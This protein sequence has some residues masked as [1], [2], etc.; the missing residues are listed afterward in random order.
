MKLNIENIDEI[1]KEN[2][3]PRVTNPVYLDSDGLPSRDG[4]FSYE[5]FG[6]PGGKKRRFQF[7][8][9][10]LTKNYI[11][12]FIYNMLCKLDQKFSDIVQGNRYVRI[13]ENG[14]LVDDDRRKN[15]D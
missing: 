15:L 6:R 10:H 7:G 9:I 4:L 8:Y 3:L 2:N 12:P 5:L 1:I 13:A 11:H 14:E